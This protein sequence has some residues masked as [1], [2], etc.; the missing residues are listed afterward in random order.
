MK[1]MQI[2]VQMFMQLGSQGTFF[3]ARVFHPKVPNYFRTQ[4]VSP[5]MRHE[6]ESK[7]NYSDRVCSV[8]CGSFTSI[9]FL[10]FSGLG[11]KVTVLYNRLNEILSKNHGTS[12]ANT[13][14]LLCYYIS[15][16]FTL[17]CYLVHQ[18]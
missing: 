9:D 8:E 14:S 17:F 12:Y 7:W 10:T 13:L 1:C 6:W 16:F 11:W 15:F 18:L 4:P 3:D 2:F 5:F